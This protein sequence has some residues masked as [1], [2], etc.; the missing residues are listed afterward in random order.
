MVRGPKIE[1]ENVLAVCILLRKA[2]KATY[3]V[4]MI[5]YLKI[6]ALKVFLANTATNT[7]KIFKIFNFESNEGPPDWPHATHGQ[8]V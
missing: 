1:G 5:L 7:V 6:K 2:L 4:K 8:R 3:L